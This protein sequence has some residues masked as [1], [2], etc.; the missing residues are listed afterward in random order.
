MSL[1]AIIAHHLYL[2]IAKI[3]MPSVIFY[4]SIVVQKQIYIYLYAKKVY[5]IKNTVKM[6]VILSEYSFFILSVY[7]HI[8]RRN[9]YASKSIRFYGE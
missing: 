5:K 9:E 2:E 4:K 1:I 8:R 7:P 6:N 3:Q